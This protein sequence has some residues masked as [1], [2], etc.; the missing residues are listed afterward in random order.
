MKNLLNTY[1]LRREE[2]LARI[3]YELELNE[4]R[5]KKMEDA[6]NAVKNH[7]DNDVDFFPDK[8]VELYPQGSK[9]IGTTVKPINNDDFDLDVVLHLHVMDNEISPNRIYQQLLKSLSKDSYYKSILEEK[10][11]CIRLNYVGDFHMDILIGCSKDN[12]HSDRLSIPEKNRLKW[13]TSSPKGFANWFESKSVISEKSMLKMFSE[14]YIMEAKIDQEELP[15][16]NI[17]EKSPLQRA[18]QLIKRYRDVYFESKDF[19]VSSIVLTTLMGVHYN[20]QTSIYETLDEVMNTILKG[21]IRVLGE[22]SRFTLKNPVDPEEDYTDS[23]TQ[24]HYNAF[25]GF[26][27]DFVRNWTEIK[28]EFNTSGSSYIELFGEGQY[29]KSLQN[30]I[31]LMSKFDT[32]HL[33]RINGLILSGNAFTDRNG[34][35]NDTKGIKNEPHKNYGE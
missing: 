9:R 21:N 10:S 16:E 7:L 12:H 31:R 8:D 5:K 20:G 3:A 19:P 27:K 30:Q 24:D 1:D 17:Y 26:V 32:D 6:Y 33:T 18:V 22:G 2:L 34:E 28:N 13:A 14:N 23:W 4:T 25:Y 15:D 11:R 29:K 35:L